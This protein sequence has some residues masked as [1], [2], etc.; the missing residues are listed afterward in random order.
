MISK[1]V[2]VFQMFSDWYFYYPLYKSLP[3]MIDSIPVSLFTFSYRGERHFRRT[4]HRSF[5]HFYKYEYGRRLLSRD[6]SITYQF[7]SLAP[8]PYYYIYPEGSDTDPTFNFVF[9]FVRDKSNTSSIWSSPPRYTIGG[10]PERRYTRLF[11]FGAIQN[12]IKQGYDPEITN[13][14]EFWDEFWNEE[15]P[16][17]Q[18]N[19]TI[20]P[21]SIC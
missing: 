17:A 3:Y 21:K 14:I 1:L 8:H 5:D 6:E 7:D 9:K 16:V 10:W 4:S 20:Q 15:F 12:E 19:L 11:W 2:F 18:P 13:L